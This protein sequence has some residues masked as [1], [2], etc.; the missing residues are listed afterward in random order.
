MFLLKWA[1]LMVLIIL[2]VYEPQECEGKFGALKGNILWFN[3]LGRGGYFLSIVLCWCWYYHA[4]LNHISGKLKASFSKLKDKMKKMGKKNNNDC[5]CKCREYWTTKC[6]VEMKNECKQL[7]THR[8]CKQ[9]PVKKPMRVKEVEC[10][11]CVRFPEL[12]SKTVTKR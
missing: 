11:K 3:W 6:S 9:I 5:N 2:L 7:Y 1:L 10:Q 8:E 4:V 12:R